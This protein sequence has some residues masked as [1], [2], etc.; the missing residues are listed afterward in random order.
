[1]G[2]LDSILTPPTPCKDESVVVFVRENLRPLCEQL[3][4]FKIR[5]EACGW[6]K[7]APV[8]ANF[9]NSAEI[10][11]KRKDSVE[12]MTVGEVKQV[13]SSLL[14]VTLDYNNGCEAACVREPYAPE[15]K[16]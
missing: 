4:D 3:R 10:D 1:M 5:M 11:E 14:Q 6:D 7:I 13:M 12:N 15:A 2:I 8:L 16:A 9:N